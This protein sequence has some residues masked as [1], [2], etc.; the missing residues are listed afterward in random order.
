VCQGRFRPGGW[1]FRL[2]FTLA[3]RAHAVE[4]RR[5]QVFFPGNIVGRISR[6]QLGL[7]FEAKEWRG[8]AVRLS[9]EFV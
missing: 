9:V 3:P 8:V 4:H 1:D 7:V 6:A 5:V 2:K